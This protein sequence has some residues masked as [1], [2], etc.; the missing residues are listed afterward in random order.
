MLTANDKD[1]EL[2]INGK[3]EEYA[4]KMNKLHESFSKKTKGSSGPKKYK[5]DYREDGKLDVFFHSIR[6]KT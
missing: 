3:I 1:R 2:D 6:Q 5:Y 4:D